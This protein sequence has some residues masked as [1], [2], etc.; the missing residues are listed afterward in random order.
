MRLA[1]VASKKLQQRGHASTGL[2]SIPKLLNSGPRGSDVASGFAPAPHHVEALLNSD[3]GRVEVLFIFDDVPFGAAGRFADV[4][5]F[6]PR[7][8]VFFVA[9]ESVRL[10]ARVRLNVQAGD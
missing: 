3:E 7:Q 1:P 4:E 10:R 9:E 2:P 8:F 5:D 6:L